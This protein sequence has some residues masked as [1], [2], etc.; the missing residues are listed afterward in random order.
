MRERES[1]IESYSI[2]LVNCLSHEVG[3]LLICLLDFR[4]MTRFLVFSVKGTDFKLLL[5]FAVFAEASDLQ[6]GI[7]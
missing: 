6:K 4:V 7:I 1:E 2:Y 3:L 5:Y